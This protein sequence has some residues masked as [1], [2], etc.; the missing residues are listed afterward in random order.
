MNLLALITACAP[1]LPPAFVDAL[2]Q[3]ESARAPYAIGMDAG[4][5]A[6]A[7][8][9]ASLKE[10]LALVE[11]LRR[12][13]KGFSVGLGQ[14]HVSNVKR[15][16]ISWKQ[17]FE[18][19]V[20]LSLA[21]KIFADYQ[22]QALL[23]GYRGEAAVLAALRGYNSGSIHYQGSTPYAQNILRRARLGA[24]A[25]LAALPQSAPAPASREGAD[26]DGFGQ[27]STAEI[28]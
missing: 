13:G 21:Q 10:A 7:R 2:V 23:H 25:P 17:A 28:F 11:Q 26:I 12:E 6:L 18:P 24:Q 5:A 27:G 3:V 1:T 15:Y 8:Q 20:N 4:A 9:P 19:C 14:I 16:R 22:T